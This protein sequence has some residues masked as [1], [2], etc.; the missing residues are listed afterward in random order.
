[1]RAVRFVEWQSE[2]ELVE[3][4][5]PVPGAGEVLIAI[6]AA[7][8]CHSDLHIMEWP[9]GAVPWQLPFTVQG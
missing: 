1:M 6:D 9:A 5:T 8:L 3:T 2:P 7:E 4:A